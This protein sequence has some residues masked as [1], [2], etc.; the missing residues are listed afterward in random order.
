[1]KRDATSQQIRA[2]RKKLLL[3]LHPDK[4][5]DLRAAAAFNRAQTAFEALTAPKGAQEE[6]RR[7]LA[8]LTWRDRER[9]RGRQLRRRR[10]RRRGEAVWGE[11]KR[12]A[13]WAAAVGRAIAF[14]Y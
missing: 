10:W 8:E 2:A 14:G 1:M 9:A 4:N 5:G 7:H 13:A 3:V 12:V 6:R 11:A